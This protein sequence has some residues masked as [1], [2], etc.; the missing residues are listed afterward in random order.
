MWWST[1]PSAFILLS[2]IHLKDLSYPVLS[3]I[4]T[5]LKHLNL[6]GD[7]QHYHIALTS[8]L[9][10]AVHNPLQPPLSSSVAEAGIMPACASLILS[11]A[12]FHLLE[13][14]YNA[15]TGGWKVG[16]EKGCA[17]TAR[18]PC[19]TLC[20]NLQP[21]VRPDRKVL[22]QNPKPSK[23]LANSYCQTSLDERTYFGIMLYL[24]FLLQHF[25]SPS[26]KEIYSSKSLKTKIISFNFIAIT[27]Q[28]HLSK[29]FSHLHIIVFCFRNHQSNT[30]KLT[31]PQ[32][33]PTA[34]LKEA[35][36]DGTFFGW[37]AEPPKPYQLD[38]G[39][40]AAL[41]YSWLLVIRKTK[42]PEF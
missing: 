29:L 30:N 40:I 42:L 18:Y 25:N 15:S 36:L 38:Q 17:G 6:Q 11:P 23:I 21:S 12:P 34:M 22:K 8:V 33:M 16:R 14:Q 13:V 7:T 1:V 32:N 27:K 5:G 4:P 37:R 3:N 39:Y 20:C 19:N 28:D 26:R 31:Y 41:K 10:S 24:F 2:W 35:L 9:Q